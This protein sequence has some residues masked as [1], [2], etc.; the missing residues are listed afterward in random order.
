MTLSVQVKTGKR[1]N[2]LYQNPEG[3]WIVEVQARPIEGEANEA[4]I[5]VIAAHF[6]IAK[7]QVRIISGHKAPHKRIEVLGK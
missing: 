2:R 7:S 4:I 6:N 3:L 5:A 1:A